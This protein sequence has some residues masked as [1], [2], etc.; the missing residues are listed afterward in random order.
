MTSAKCAVLRARQLSSLKREEKAEWK[1][2]LYIG[3]SLY[4]HEVFA[5]F[6]SELMMDLAGFTL[7]TQLV[8]KTRQAD[9]QYIGPWH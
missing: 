9:N 7:N 2:G 5:A 6:Q 3:Q 8:D 1:S 4:L